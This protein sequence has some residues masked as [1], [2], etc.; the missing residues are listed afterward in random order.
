MRTTNRLLIYIAA[1]LI[2][3]GNADKHSN[4]QEDDTAKK[5]DIHV[6]DCPPSNVEDFLTLR[7]QVAL[8][9]EENDT[10]EDDDPFLFLVEHLIGQAHG[11]RNWKNAK[12][13]Q[14]ISN[15]LTVSDEAFVLLSIENCWDAIQEEIQD[16]EDEEGGNG[17]PGVY[18]RGKYTNHGTNSR[19]GGWSPEGI[20]RFN[21]LYELVEKNRN[22]PWA[23]KVDE[24]VN[25]RLL[26]RHH[27]TM[28]TTK[29]RRK[30]R[31]IGSADQQEVGQEVVPVKARSSLSL[32][33]LPAGVNLTAI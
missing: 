27:R 29:V 12:C 24:E 25:K 4:E 17:K 18:T 6:Y 31:H 22:E 3:K 9:E 30:K 5:I 15:T 26:F 13:F 28:N 33:K 11:L 10:I 20:K 23:K 8:E 16:N 32:F 21:E 2:N 1:R 14:R 19:Y 7:P